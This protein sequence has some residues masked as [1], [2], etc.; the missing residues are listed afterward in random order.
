MRA[1][2]TRENKEQCGKW[3]QDGWREG[4]WL[5]LIFKWSREVE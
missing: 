4:V 1:H 5:K 2:F 3:E